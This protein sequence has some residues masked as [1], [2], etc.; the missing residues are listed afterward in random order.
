MEFNDRLA[1][2]NIDDRS[3]HR[4]NYYSWDYF[5]YVRRAPYNS[6]Y[7]TSR[8]RALCYVLYGCHNFGYKF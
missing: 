7:L 4:A 8:V 5:L 3:K 2:R 6:V 1:K